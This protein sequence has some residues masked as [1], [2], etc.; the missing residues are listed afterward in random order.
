[1]TL[2]VFFGFAILQIG[3]SNF[4]YPALQGH[5]LSL[6]P[7]AIV[8]ATPSRQLGSREARKEQG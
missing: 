2:V 7:V 8:A 1:M 5:Q 6:S 4:I 3:I